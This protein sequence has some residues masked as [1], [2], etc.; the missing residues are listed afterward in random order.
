MRLPALAI[1]L[2]ALVQTARA[3]EAAYRACLG[4]AGANE[5][6]LSRCGDE[7]ATRAEAAMGAAFK[8]ALGDM[9]GEAAKKALAEEQAA[10]AAFR[11][12]SCLMFSSGDFPR[13]V[14]AVSFAVCRAGLIEARA[15]YLKGLTDN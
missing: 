13:D 9:P 14:G 7:W 4:K 6:A 10:W 15:K 1:A 8:S 2:L 3:D 11:D 12:K 5:T